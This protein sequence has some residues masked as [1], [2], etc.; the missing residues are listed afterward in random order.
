MRT[1]A[2]PDLHQGSKDQSRTVILYPRS[3]ILSNPE[4]LTADLSVFWLVIR[5]L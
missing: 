2:I 5:H 1:A 4:Y 3:V